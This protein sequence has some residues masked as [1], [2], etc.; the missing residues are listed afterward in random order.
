MEQVKLLSMTVVLTAL[1]W[2]SADSLVNETV[3]IDVSFEILPPRDTPHMLL[4]PEGD[5]TLCELEISGPRKAVEAAQAQAPLH[6]R[7]RIADRPTGASLIHLDREDVRRA[8]S[9]LSKEFRKLTV[10]AV[11][12][13]TLQIQIDHRIEREVNV[14][15][16]RLALSYDSEPQ[17]QRVTAT[18]QMRESFFNTLPL[19]QPL[20]SEIGPEIERLLDEQPAGESVTVSV[21]L[22]A[23]SFGLGAVITP[24]TVDVTA[25]VQAR[26][27][28]TQIPTVPILLAM[29]FANLE[30]PLQPV[31][32]DGTP[33]SLVTQTIT[34]TGLREVVARLQRGETRAYG[35]IQLKQEDLDALDVIKLVT[36]DYFLPEG[37]ELALEGVPIEFKLIYFSKNGPG[38]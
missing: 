38:S 23:R 36:P 25:T 5:A 6:L 9:E 2:A 19:N 22:D 27:V 29:S 35:V 16:K 18:V 21:T 8:L 12:P 3:T 32:R 4:A 13:D 10:S 37:V 30:R 14:V 26:R 11:Q 31:T 34:V 20:Q 15:A 7:L 24:A 1:V 33:L 17:F 28:T